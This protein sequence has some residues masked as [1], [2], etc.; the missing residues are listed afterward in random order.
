M[1]KA[2]GDAAVA[3]TLTAQTVLRLRCRIGQ[4]LFLDK[5]LANRDHRDR[6]IGE[7]SADC[8]CDSGADHF[9]Y[10]DS[11][12]PGAVDAHPDRAAFL[13]ELASDLRAF[14]RG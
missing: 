6:P 1:L 10:M 14:A 7:A 8:R 2:K 11:P 5:K 12:P 9:T 3:T 4:H 13:R